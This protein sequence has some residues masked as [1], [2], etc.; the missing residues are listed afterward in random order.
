VVRPV[1]SWETR[2]AK[3]LVAMVKVLVN[4]LTSL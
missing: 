4:V 3:K 1:I 2:P